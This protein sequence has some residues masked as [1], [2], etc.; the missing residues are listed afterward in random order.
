MLF[1]AL[2]NSFKEQTDSMSFE[3][4]NKNPQI[5]ALRHL[6]PLILVANTSTPCRSVVVMV[7]NL[8]NFHLRKNI[9][10]QIFFMFT[11]TQGNEPI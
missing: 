3:P 4:H 1:C 9:G 8:G 10:A 7:V 2:K 6:A 11:P 5:N